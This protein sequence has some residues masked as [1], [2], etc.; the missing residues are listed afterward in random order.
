[1]ALALG[2]FQEA[3]DWSE[4]RSKLAPLKFDLEN[5]SLLIGEDIPFD[6]SHR[7][8]S[9]TMAIHPLGILNIEQSTEAKAQ[10]QASVRQLIDHG[11]HQWVGY[12]FTWAAS[13][14]ARAGF[15]EDCRRLLTD[16]ERAFVT[17]NGFHVNGDQSKTGLSGFQYRPFTLEGNFLF[18][19]AIQEMYLQ[20][21]GG[22]I[23]I[24]PTVPDAWKNCHFNNLRA[25]GGLKVSASR[26]DGLTNSIEIVA[27]KDGEVTL[28]DPFDGNGI[29]NKRVLRQSSE[30][31][32]FQL[33]AT[34][35]LKGKRD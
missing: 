17:R 30:W 9:H 23:R 19:D 7:H 2:K 35:T 21:W 27:S 34:E 8:F 18:M 22:K 11:S 20:S 1:M 28:R 16:F 6:H 13:L 26:N 4:I 25:E 14:A 15:P 3:K 5:D 12:S 24:F 29:W 33:L 32:T 31:T 10:V